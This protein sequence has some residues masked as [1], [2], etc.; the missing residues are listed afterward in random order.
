MRG[1]SDTTRH[2]E[3]TAH[4][5]LFALGLKRRGK[6]ATK[7]MCKTFNEVD[8]NTR[9]TGLFE[10]SFFKFLGFGL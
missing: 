1:G 5:A 8:K 7:A 4:E 10:D 2:N 6:E 9:K 3:T